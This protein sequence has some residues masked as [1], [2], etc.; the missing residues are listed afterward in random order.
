MGS[1]FTQIFERMTMY[2]YRSTL[3]EIA[4]NGSI[5]LSY[6]VEGLDN[7]TSR[8]DRD[9]TVAEAHIVQW[10]QE[11]NLRDQGLRYANIVEF[12]AYFSTH[13]NENRI[14][15]C[16]S[17]EY[18]GRF[19]SRVAYSVDSET[20]ERLIDYVPLCSELRE[21]TLVTPGSSTN[22][23][24]RAKRRDNFVFGV[25]TMWFLAGVIFGVPATAVLSIRY[26]FTIDP[27]LTTVLHFG[28]LCFSTW[29]LARLLRVFVK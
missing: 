16:G 25:C 19:P 27:A 3:A 7:V 29:L 5:T 17:E 6:R 15:S 28:V 20:G 13:P 10:A 1:L 9:Q 12:V 14:V 23:F 22:G 2:T 26:G 21:W 8:F 11:G 18:G 24:G 4:N